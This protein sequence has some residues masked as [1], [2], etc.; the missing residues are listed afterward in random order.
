MEALEDELDG[1][2]DL[3]AGGGVAVPE[4]VEDLGQPALAREAYGARRSQG[5]LVV[6][7]SSACRSGDAE[8][9]KRAIA[10]LRGDA[11]ETVLGICRKAGIDV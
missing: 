10:K 4:A 7:A 5:A 8:S 3:T 6:M 11:K 9:A 1:C 2:G